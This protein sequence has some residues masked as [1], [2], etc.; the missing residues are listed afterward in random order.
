M[1]AFKTLLFAMMMV[2][3][4]Q[5]VMAQQQEFGEEWGA[6]ATQEERY[7][8]VLKFNF[9]KDAYDN[10]KY[11]VALGYMRDL[12]RDAP[13]AKMNIYVWGTNIYR[14]KIA[15]ATSVN[16]RNLY[17]DSLM[18]LYDLRAEHFAD[19]PRY[20][21]AYIMK[22]KA[23]DYYN[24]RAS[25]KAGVLKVFQDAI[26]ASADV[27]A[28][29][30]A[31]YFQVLTEQYQDLDIE[32][33][34]YMDEYDRMVK[35]LE[36]TSEQEHKDV[37]ENL[38][39]NSGAANCENLEKIYKPRFAANSTDVAQLKKA[40]AL[41]T[42]SDC[43]TPFYFEVGDMLLA[44]EPTAETAMSLAKGY[45]K[46][47]DLTKSIEYLTKA[48]EAEQDPFTKS[49]L[50]IQIAGNEIL[51]N[52]PRNAANFAKQAIEIN[53][54]SGMAY[55]V[56]AQAYAAGSGVCSG[57]ERLTVYW[58]AYDTIQNA[59][60]LLADDE[61]QVAT[62]DQLMQSFRNSFPN[63]EECFFRGLNPGDAFTVNCG[64]ISGRTTVK[65]GK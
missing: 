29:F 15:A 57:F 63:K 61:A 27:D 3:G 56:L 19:D 39:I 1:K 33:E 6:N 51:N 40:F 24:Y 59:R 52:N 50:A 2:F 31:Q 36:T 20:G 42:R 47:G 8:N 46:Q 4:A 64:W 16:E 62:I 54:E 26:A 49:Q 43:L 21:Y 41:L 22:S 60:R 25:D 9:Y 37:V 13:K 23:K 12:L 28:D 38:F 18:M 17:T 44:V 55:V 65:E 14:R 32:T 30:I 53:P 11:D 34:L 35:L 7:Q 58:L 5:T 45:E 48:I 10:K